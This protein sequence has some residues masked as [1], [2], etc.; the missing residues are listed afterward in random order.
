M[1]IK[2]IKIKVTQD[3]QEFDFTEFF[4]GSNTIYTTNA[5]L[6]QEEDGL[7]W[8]AFF[9]YKNENN[10]EIPKRLSKLIE[11]EKAPSDYEEE[12]LQLI[13]KNN[14]I[15]ARVRNA[16]Q[17]NLDAIYY[18]KTI[19]EF[20]KLRNLGKKSILENEAFFNEILTISRKHR[21][22]K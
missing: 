4:T 18:F 21:I 11:K 16:I 14:D 19:N 8:H 15:S 2:T 9:T 6:I 22:Q 13:R 1:K 3:N 17:C 7:Y 20:E 10:F 12:V 5:Q